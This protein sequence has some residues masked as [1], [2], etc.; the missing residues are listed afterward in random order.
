MTYTLEMDTLGVCDKSCKLRICYKP[1][2]KRLQ[3]TLAHLTRSVLV[4]ACLS[5]LMAEH[6]WHNA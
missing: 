3:S 6:R 5:Q 1:F 2:Q 4:K